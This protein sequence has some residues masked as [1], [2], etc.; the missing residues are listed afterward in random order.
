AQLDDYVIDLAWS[1]SGTLVAA[2]S[3]AGPVSIF[4]AADGPRLHEL[5]G[6]A[7]GTNCLA[8]QPT[9]AVETAS[10]DA[11]ILATGGQDGAVKFWDASAGQ[12]TATAKLG[13]GWVEH[14]GWRPATH[15]SAESSSVH[16]SNSPCLFAA[17]GKQL[18]ALRADASLA[19][20][21]K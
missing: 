2:A 3:A 10:P 8:W 7:D 5:P 17:A 1:P 15:S 4:S 16:T 21:F 20:A 14:L 6:H 12:H 19:H 11:A 13:T 9:A 18:H